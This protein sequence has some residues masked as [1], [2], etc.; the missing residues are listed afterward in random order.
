MG[1]WLFERMSTLSASPTIMTLEAHSFDAVTATGIVL[2]D[3]SAPWCG[4]CQMQSPILED[5]VNRVG[6]TVVIG[7]VDVDDAPDLAVRYDIL[8]IPTLILMKDG[9][10]VQRFVGVQSA[11]VLAKAVQAVVSHDPLTPNV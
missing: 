9:Q 8:S 2:V 5:L 10:V 11:S 4:P 3:F 1:S 7:K 6:A